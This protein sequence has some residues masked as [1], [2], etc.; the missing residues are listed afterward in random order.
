MS[1][2]CMNIV[3]ASDDNFADIMG[4]SALSLLANN[5]DFDEI[6]LYVLDG[7]ISQINK[8]RIT[9]VCKSFGRS[10]PCWLKA[11]VSRLPAGINTD[12]GSISQYAR[13]FIGSLLPRDADRVLY[14]DC[15]IIIN[16]SLKELWD[17]DL[18]GNTIG[19]L[20]DAFSKLYRGNI[21]LRPTDIMFNSG[22][23]LIDLRKWRSRSIEDKLIRFI[24]KKHGKLQQGDQGVLNAVL[25]HETFCL[26][27]KFN[28]VTIFYDFTY[29]EML[30]YRDPPVFYSREQVRQAAEAPVIIHFT[31]SFLSKRPWVEGCKHRYAKIWLS[32]KM[33]SP[34]KDEPLR[35]APA[36][37]GLKGIY[38][39][40]CEK[41]PRK[42]ML[43][44]SRIFQVYGRPLLYKLCKIW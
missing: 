42:L 4:I 12:R 30:Y 31:T 10:E 17:T 19:A 22:V 3:Y 26:E 32:Y 24:A 14:L 6:R 28:S 25:S 1:D 8:E 35:K 16:H 18:Q 37:K 43:F 13:L 40:L 34:W 23:M 15:D 29:D 41:A 27:P 20:N 11:D 39:G 44:V 2:N 38:I 36:R 9:G 33:Q 21:D 5:K 7:G